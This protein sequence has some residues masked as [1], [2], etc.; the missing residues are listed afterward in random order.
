MCI[1]ILI[2]TSTLF[3]PTAMP[4]SPLQQQQLPEQMTQ[5]EAGP[6]IIRFPS[7]GSAASIQEIPH[8]HEGQPDFNRALAT[9]ARRFHVKEDD[10]DAGTER[11]DPHAPLHLALHIYHPHH[12]LLAT[13]SWLPAGN[14]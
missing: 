5:P 7:L 6:L 4:L 1:S 11:P 3:H 2:P 14:C 9:I 8:D 13:L 10:M 12:G